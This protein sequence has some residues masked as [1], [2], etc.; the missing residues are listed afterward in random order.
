M[1][2][3]LKDYQ[4]DAVGQL[5]GTLR[6]A[7]EIAH[8]PVPQDSS[9]ALTAPTGAGKTVVAAAVIEALFFGSDA[10]DMEPDPGAIV[11]WF[12]DDPHLNEQSRFRLLQASEKLTLDRLVRIR[13]P[14]GLR[15]LKAGKVYF[16]NTQ[17][18]SRTSLLTR[19]H[20]EEEVAGEL[21]GFKAAA[22]PDGLAWNI[23][24]TI[25][26]TVRDEKHT[27]YLL[28]DEAHRG[29]DG[30]AQQERATIV[31]R[32][33]SGDTHRRA[34]PIVV[35]IS[36][37]IERFKRAMEAADVSGSRL[38][39]P[40][41]VVPPAKVLA[42]GLI[43]DFINLTIPAEHGDFA[44]SLVTE[45]AHR[46]VESDI[47]W[48][49]YATE[50]DSSD[51][52]S[53]LL[54]LQIPNT[55]DHDEVGLLLDAIQA[56]IPELD[57]G[58]LRH[59]LS[60]RRTEKFGRWELDWIEPQRVQDSTQVR[61]LVAKEAVSTGWDCPRAEVLVSLR[62]AKDQ[63]HIAQL[64]GRMVR[65]PLARRI[66][67]NDLMNSV[68]CILPYF[69]RT[70]AGH[71]VKYMTGQSE[72]LPP[73]GA[74]RVL[75]DGRQMTPNPE[76]GEDVWEEFDKLP[77]Q[78]VPQRGSRPV[79]RLVALAHALAMDTIHPGALADATGRLH[80]WLDG[81]ART[82]RAEVDAAIQEIWKVH[83]ATLTGTT[84]GAGVKYVV[85]T[86][87]ADDRA[88]RAGMEEAKR[89]FGADVAQGYVRHIVKAAKGDDGLQ[90]A[91][92]LVAALATVK[93]LR[94]QID[95][96]ADALAATWFTD[97]ESEIKRLTDTRQQEYEDIR[98]LAT[99]PQ[100][101]SL[102]RPRI[103][104]EDFAV[105][106]DNGDI[107]RAPLAR[108]HLMSDA[109][110]NFPVGQLNGW[111]QEIVSL[112]VG[113]SDS[114]G[115]YR[116]PSQNS[117]DSLTIAYRDA[118]GDWRSLH[119]DFIFFNRADERVRASIIDPHGL[120]LGMVEDSLG[121]LQGLAAF[122]ER[123]GD[124]F[125]RIGAVIKHGDSWRMLD[126]QRSDVRA[127]VAAHEGATDSLYFSVVSVAYN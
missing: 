101:T 24:E 40:D 11:I 88:I 28:L 37:T 94:E 68:D 106:V 126:M 127:A 15:Q 42:S 82:Y 36:A 75:L 72:E 56:V 4:A 45:A 95:K 18:L 93:P 120:Q 121:K 9:L 12:S 84:G 29:F 67:G 2:L 124:S 111:E 13:P 117:V 70:T 38:S 113:R 89:V 26:N 91:Y 104:L 110:G 108:S 60:E 107:V 20:R 83:L 43:K 114:A 17:R 10:W 14:F 69:D 71:V 58:A 57:G 6:Q 92:V 65:S 105:A 79:K 44:T 50:D 22:P 35:G 112:E 8:A 53:P 115:W 46:L 25:D 73:I 19:G 102:R 90:D 32:L 7:R 116:N 33:I 31:R 76:I 51:P 41:V 74:G 119:P 99:E 86:T 85:H 48:R 87:L 118:I 98:S 125:D 54:V 103:R 27:V 21:E 1:K 78:A 52:V 30:R 34:I 59:V 55:P 123:H 96:D 81:L 61:V 39:L 100:R 47:R 3:T 63:T 80:E 77:T 64:L 5:L 23:W 109:A 62:P 16:L 122:A 49:R 66:P 97:Y